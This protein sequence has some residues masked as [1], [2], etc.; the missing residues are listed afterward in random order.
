MPEG[1]PLAQRETVA[2]EDLL[3]VPLI[4]SEGTPDSGP[5]AAWCGPTLPRLKVA[6]TYSLAFNASV[7]VREGLGCAIV[8]DRL[9]AAGPGTGLEFR[10]LYPPAVCTIELTWR[11]D[12]PMTPAARAMLE[13]LGKKMPRGFSDGFTNRH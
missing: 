5:L 1:H 4:V 3:N 6:G 10:P 12:Q 9:V 11:R 7:L 8:F 13:Y 2:P